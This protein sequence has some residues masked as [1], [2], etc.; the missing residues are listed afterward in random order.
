MIRTWSAA[1]L[2][3]TLALGLGGCVAYDP[4]PF[5]YGPP[6]VGYYAPPPPPVYGYGY[7]PYGGWHGH[8]HW[9]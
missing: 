9:R 7:R 5:Y 2:G 4:G 8:G 1:L 6:S 3:L